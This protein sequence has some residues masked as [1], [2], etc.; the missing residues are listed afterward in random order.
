MLQN[1]LECTAIRDFTAY[2]NWDFG[3]FSYIVSSIRVDN[4]MLVDNNA[5]MCGCRGYVTNAKLTDLMK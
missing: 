1:N 4:V 3:V 5:G 2:K